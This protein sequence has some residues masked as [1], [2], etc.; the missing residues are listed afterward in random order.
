MTNAILTGANAIPLM[1]APNLNSRGHC[2]YAAAVL[3]QSQDSLLSGA[4]AVPLG[5][6]HV[7]SFTGDRRP[8]SFAGDRRPAMVGRCAGWRPD[9]ERRAEVSSFP[10]PPQSI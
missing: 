2:S 4:N 7:Q 10:R 3:H 9:Q 8:A 1:P 5:D 6:A